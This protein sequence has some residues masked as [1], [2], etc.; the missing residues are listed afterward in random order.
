MW[1]KVNN[2]LTR[3]GLWEVYQRAADLPS[4]WDDFTLDNIFL[5]RDSLIFLEAVNPC[6]QI[7]YLCPSQ[8]LI[9]VTYRLKLDLATF[10]RHTLLRIPVRIVGIPLSVSRPGYAMPPGQGAADALAGCLR[11][12]SGFTLVLNGGENLPLP[13]GQTLPSY[14]MQLPWRDFRA[15]LA[16]L[17]SPYR[18]RL[19]RALRKGRGLVFAALEDNSAFDATMY[20]LYL[21]V[22]RHSAAKLE[23]QPIEYFQS[24]PGRIFLFWEDDLLL[25]FVQL[26]EADGHL[27]FVLGGFRREANARVDLYLNMLLA[28]VRYGVERGCRSIDFGQ[29]ADASKSVIGGRAVPKFMYIAHRST[30]LEYA[31]AWLTPVLSHRPY[32]KIHHV[33]RK[34]GL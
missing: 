17:R 21:E 3:K 1:I 12:L 9:F 20:A 11:A 7:Y 31:L 8:G 29:T 10:T 32:Q 23:L 15:Y 27:T 30:W 13:K 6:Q 22:Y 33:F 34:R 28:I 18:R 25:G 19:C 24:Y 26:A 16:A 4:Y 14:E 2:P 5:R